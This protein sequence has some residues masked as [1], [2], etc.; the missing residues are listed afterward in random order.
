[1]SSPNAPAYLH[2]R[3][4]LIDR[5]DHQN[6]PASAVLRDYDGRFF[7]RFDEDWTDDQIFAALDF[8]NQAYR[9]GHGA[10][11]RDK[12]YEIRRAI[13]ALSEEAL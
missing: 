9:E 1:M 4:A 2:R 5:G 3:D 8:A 10:G 13:G 12:A 6:Y 11:Q 7:F